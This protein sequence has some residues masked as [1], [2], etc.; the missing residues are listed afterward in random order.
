MVQQLFF[1]DHEFSQFCARLS[2]ACTTFWPC[3][4]DTHHVAQPRPH[5][6]RTIRGCNSN[7]SK[8]SA[9]QGRKKIGRS[10][11][12]AVCGRT[13][14]FGYHFVFE[15][16]PFVKDIEDTPIDFYWSGV[17]AQSMCNGFERLDFGF[18][19]LSSRCRRLGCGQACGNS[20]C[21]I[22]SNR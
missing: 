17:G 11:L 13:R 22:F 2:T 10:N 20:V 3:N 1:S 4:I 21:P 12:H 6:R 7:E 19:A 15:I 14:R 16:L 8:A 5:P 9:P 18:L